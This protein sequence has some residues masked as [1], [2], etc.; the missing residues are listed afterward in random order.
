MPMLTELARRPVW[1]CQGGGP[2]GRGSRGG[3]ARGGQG[4]P[5]P[6]PPGQ[7]APATSTSRW[8]VLRRRG[9]AGLSRCPRDALPARPLS[10]CVWLQFGCRTWLHRL[11][12]G[13]EGRW[14]VGTVPSGRTQEYRDPRGWP[15]LG[16]GTP[17][18]RSGVAPHGHERLSGAKCLLLVL[19]L[20]RVSSPSRRQAASTP[21]GLGDSTNWGISRLN[22]QP[23]PAWTVPRAQASG[24]PLCT[25]AGCSA[26]RL[27]L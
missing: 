24:L 18:T 17:S 20:L 6:S 22:E 10:W 12:S 27:A 4:S 3:Q 1:H 7:Q 25:K 13:R 16:L 2:V 21:A 5:W 9:D 26:V 23:P 11:Q 14:R 15:G 8:S 19:L